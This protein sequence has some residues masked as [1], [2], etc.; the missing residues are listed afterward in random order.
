[1]LVAAWFA[2]VEAL[3]PRVNDP[4]AA[5]SKIIAVIRVGGFKGLCQESHDPDKIKLP[6][7]RH[8]LMSFHGG[9]EMRVNSLLA[10]AMFKF[11]EYS[12]LPS[13]VWN[14]EWN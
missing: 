8:M 9:F 12:K 14:K 3:A 2:S 6:G 10:Q 11:D 7:K 1:M 5:V 13:S 4:R